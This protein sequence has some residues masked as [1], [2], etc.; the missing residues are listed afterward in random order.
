MTLNH[1][2]CDNIGYVKP[3]KQKLFPS[4]HV[5]HCV[6]FT[7][8]TSYWL[9]RSY[10]FRILGISILEFFAFTLEN[11]VAFNESG[12]HANVWYFNL[13]NVEIPSLGITKYSSMNDLGQSWDAKNPQ[14]SAC[15]DPNVLLLSRRWTVHLSPCSDEGGSMFMRTQRQYWCK[16]KC[17]HWH[18]QTSF[19]H[20]HHRLMT[21]FLFQ[22]IVLTCTFCNVWKDKKQSK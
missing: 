5:F 1:K 8:A 21:G 3:V 7:W 22:S 2:S 6:L 16:H 18:W 9:I 12:G 4:S 11:S 10:S 17:V 13:G 20:S 15:D 19:W 14:K